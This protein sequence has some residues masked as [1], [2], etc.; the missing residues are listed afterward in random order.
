[1]GSGLVNRPQLN[2]ERAV[3]QLFDTE[4][5]RYEVVVESTGEVRRIRQRNLRA[6][7]KQVFDDE[8]CE[9]IRFTQVLGAPFTGAARSQVEAALRSAAMNKTEGALQAAIR[10]LSMS[11]KAEAAGAGDIVVEDTFWAVADDCLHRRT[12]V[13]VGGGVAAEAYREEALLGG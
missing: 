1:M 7:D 10:T 12:R 6:S 13:L 8:P 3:V 2:G 11:D 5:G 4:S 9:C